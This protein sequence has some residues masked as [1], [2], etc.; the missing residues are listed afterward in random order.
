MCVSVSVYVCV[1]LFGLNGV[2][3]VSVD[4]GV[5]VF[6]CLC[7]SVLVTLRVLDSGRVYS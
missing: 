1:C 3:R 6:L 2:M 4:E 7:V 5:S